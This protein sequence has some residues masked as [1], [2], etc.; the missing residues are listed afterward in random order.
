MWT[1]Q[2]TDFNMTRRVIFTADTVKFKDWIRVFDVLFIETFP[3]VPLCAFLSDICV[4]VKFC[5]L[6]N[7]PETYMITF[8]TGLF[9]G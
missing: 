3:K 5:F 7:K 4:A 1:F 8:K 2:I 9:F 6:Q